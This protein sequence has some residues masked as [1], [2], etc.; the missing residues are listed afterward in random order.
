MKAIEW[1]PIC[2]GTTQWRTREMHRCTDA[3]ELQVGHDAYH[4][5]CISGHLFCTLG[6]SLDPEHKSM[7]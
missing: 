1:R 3:I 4:N 2:E 5:F 6:L 7:G